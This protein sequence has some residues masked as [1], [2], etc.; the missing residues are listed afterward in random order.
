MI[1][2]ATPSTAP[3]LNNGKV[4]RGLSEPNL[5]SE[6][7]TACLEAHT[8]RTHANGRANG[9]CRLGSR[10]LPEVGEV[11]EQDVSIV[12]R[13]EA[14]HVVLGHLAEVLPVQSLEHKDVQ[15]LQDVL[16]DGPVQPLAHVVMAPHLRV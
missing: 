6:H 7:R 14:H 1:T 13:R 8:A 16:L 15:L 9:E 11:G 12:G 4:K 5:S 10:T 3:R 2:W